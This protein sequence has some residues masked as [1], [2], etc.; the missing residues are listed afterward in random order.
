[1]QEYIRGRIKLSECASKKAIKDV[2]DQGKDLTF[3][4]DKNGKLVVDYV[5]AV[6]GVRAG[7]VVAGFLRPEETDLNLIKIKRESC[8][9]A[10]LLKENGIS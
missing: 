7:A 2:M 8:T 1:M 10:A 5:P 6:F 4:K 3:V 9:L